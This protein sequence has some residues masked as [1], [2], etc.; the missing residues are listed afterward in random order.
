MGW[1]LDGVADQR[2]GH[3]VRAAATA[4]ELGSGDGDHLDARFAQQRV[5]IDVALIPHDHAGREAQQVV[6][7]VAAPTLRLCKP[8]AKAFCS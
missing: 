3:A 7:A 8:G 5:G 2:A 4:S 1:S 6:G